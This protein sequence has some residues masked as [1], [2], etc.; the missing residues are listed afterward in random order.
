MHATHGSYVT[1]VRS[2]SSRRCLAEL[3]HLINSFY[4]RYLLPDLFFIASIINN[5]GEVC[6]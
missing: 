3:D 4:T 5:F 6:H 1:Y 2:S